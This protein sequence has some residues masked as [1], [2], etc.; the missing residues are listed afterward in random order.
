VGLERAA[1]LGEIMRTFIGGIGSRDTDAESIGRLVSAR[2][3]RDAP[4]NAAGVVVA[5]VN[6]DPLDL[7]ARLNGE[8]PKF[9]RVI[10][11]GAVARERPAGTVT[12][13][14]WDGRGPNE[15]S[16]DAADG[17]GDGIAFD[18]A[19]LTVSS[20]ADLPDDV[21]VVEIEPETESPNA[22]SRAVERARTLVRR[23]ATNASAATTLPE[24]ALG[25]FLPRPARAD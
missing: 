25:D 22:G 11:V 4:I 17:D 20:L 10:F 2:L 21:I 8:W 3:A 19:V 15:G 14:K 23:L 1:S 9:E 13:Y 16:R 7:A 24:C 6:G 18:S 12:A 5:D